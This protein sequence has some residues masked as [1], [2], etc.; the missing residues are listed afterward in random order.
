MFWKTTAWSWDD[1]ADNDDGGYLLAA[2]LRRTSDSSLDM[3]QNPIPTT[4]G[5]KALTD[6]NLDPSN[7]SNPSNPSDPSN[8][9]CS[10][11]ASTMCVNT[12][13]RQ[14]TRETTA[15]TH[16]PSTVPFSSGSVDLDLVQSGL[17]LGGLR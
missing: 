3:D 13:R 16:T 10:R 2:D 14:A 8:P 4:A 11:Y 7:P 1:A 15:A 17:L 12:N 5:L 6:H 9:I